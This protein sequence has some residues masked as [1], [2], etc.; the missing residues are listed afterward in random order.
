[1]YTPFDFYSER[2]FPTAKW[3][4][5]ATG[6]HGKFSFLSFMCYL[7]VLILHANGL[8]TSKSGSHGRQKKKPP[9]KNGLK[10]ERRRVGYPNE[11]GKR[12]KSRM[13]KTVSISR[14]SGR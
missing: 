2:V 1:L 3:P 9:D 10:S 12:M 11:K 6:P 14:T 4:F 5:E 7:R 8:G 13:Y